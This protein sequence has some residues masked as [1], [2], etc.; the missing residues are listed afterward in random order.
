M[1]ACR[2]HR[3][4]QKPPFTCISEI[5]PSNA[6][7]RMD[8]MTKTHRLL[9][10]SA[11]LLAIV[12]GLAWLFRPADGYDPAQVDQRLAGLREPYASVLTGFVADGGSLTMMITDSQGETLKI[13]IPG[14]MGDTNRHT[15]LFFGATYDTDPGAEEVPDPEHT[16]RMLQSILLSRRS[17][18][19]Y[20]DFLLMCT[21]GRGI[22]YIRC[23][24][25]RLTGRY[26]DE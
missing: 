21:R 18:D 24:M 17:E 20:A 10:L 7:V 13:A 1:T 15:R 22:D 3:Q 25:N 9:F 12:G 16:F 19:S 5:K 14:R 4:G 8:E 26:N 23:W 2:H 11:L 6:A